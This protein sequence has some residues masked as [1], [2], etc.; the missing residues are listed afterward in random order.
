MWEQV[1]GNGKDPDLDTMCQKGY[2]DCKNDAIAMLDCHFRDDSGY[3]I[4]KLIVNDYNER[5]NRADYQ[6]YC[7]HL[8]LPD[9]WYESDTASVVEHQHFKPVS[10]EWRDDLTAILSQFFVRLCTDYVKV[11]I[12][13]PVSPQGDL[14]RAY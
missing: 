4:Q 3:P 8:S 1:I 14:P 2:E 5:N 9:G 10:S 12:Q 7:Q 13:L 6:K 11:K